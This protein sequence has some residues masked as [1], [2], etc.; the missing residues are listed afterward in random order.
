MKNGDMQI[1][2][3]SPTAGSSIFYHN[4]DFNVT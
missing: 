2:H 1:S 3:D 4:T